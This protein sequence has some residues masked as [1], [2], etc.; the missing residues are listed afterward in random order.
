VGEREGGG[1]AMTVTYTPA[2]RR[3]L[4]ALDRAATRRVRDAVHAYAVDPVADTGHAWA[5]A[6]GA[7][8]RLAVGPYRVLFSLERADGDDMVVHAVV[9]KPE[10]AH[11][12]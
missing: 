1:M 9:R 2:A 11:G 5:L 3:D 10:T 4:G 7:G 8:Y 12:G 6:H